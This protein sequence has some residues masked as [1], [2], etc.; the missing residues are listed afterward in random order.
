MTLDELHLLR[1]LVAVQAGLLPTKQEENVFKAI[2]ILDREIKL[3]TMDPRK[4]DESRRH[5]TPT[6]TKSI[7]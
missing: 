5:D 6:N 4:S 7:S 3:K 1:Y 2:F